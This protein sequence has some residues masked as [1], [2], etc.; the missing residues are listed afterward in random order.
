M[1]DFGVLCGATAL[2]SPLNPPI[3]LMILFSSL[4][5]NLVQAEHRAMNDF[6]DCS[7]LKTRLYG[8]TARRRVEDIQSQLG[9]CRIML[10]FY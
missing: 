9:I 6:V 10:K 8:I 2:V 3:H 5:F 4:T 7:S 1:T